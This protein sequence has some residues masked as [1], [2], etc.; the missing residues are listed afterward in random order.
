MM[1]GLSAAGESSQ[2]DLGVW[3]LRL[4]LT[5]QTGKKQGCSNNTELGGEN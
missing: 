1:K 2:Q 3:A 5:L 4:Q